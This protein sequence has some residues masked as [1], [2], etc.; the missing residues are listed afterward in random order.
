MKLKQLSRSPHES[1]VVPVFRVLGFR[2]QPGFRAQ[3][4][5]TAWSVHKTLFGFRA[6]L[7]CPFLL[8]IALIFS[9]NVEFSGN[10][11]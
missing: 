1:T 5:A 11:A 3:K 7:S 2:A 10:L 6:P 8:R 4:P 9:K